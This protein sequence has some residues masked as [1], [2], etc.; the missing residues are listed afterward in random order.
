MCE[1][2]KIIVIYKFYDFFFGIF[3]FLIEICLGCFINVEGRWNESYVLLIEMVLEVG[4]V[5]VIWF[6]FVVEIVW[7]YFCVFFIICLLLLNVWK[8]NV[9]VNMCVNLI[10]WIYLVV[11]NLI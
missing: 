8:I 4:L 9:L 1:W 5:F 2:D 10:W 7:Y 11:V 6:F 3:L